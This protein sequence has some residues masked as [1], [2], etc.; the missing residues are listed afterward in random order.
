MARLLSLIFNRHLGSVAASSAAA[1]IV[2]RQR[3]G[4]LGKVGCSAAS[5]A[6]AANQQR[7]GILGRLLRRIFRRRL[8]RLEGAGLV[9]ASMFAPNQFDVIL[10]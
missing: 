1:A 3:R 2:A 4:I 8:C 9:Q 6:A 7:R 5:A 10:N